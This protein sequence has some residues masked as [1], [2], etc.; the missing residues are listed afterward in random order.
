MAK[1][2]GGMMS[3]PALVGAAAP[4]MTHSDGYIF[5]IIRNG[6]GLMPS[7][8]RIEESERWDVVNYIRTLQGRTGIAIDTTHGLPGETGASL[9]PASSTAPT[10]PVP[11]F[12]VT[13]G[14]LHQVPAAGPGA[15]ADTAH[16]PAAAPAAPP[17]ARPDSARPPATRPPAHPEFPK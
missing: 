14:A 10:R 13:P 12:R 2:T 17:V 3:A 15:P 11:Y 8:N 7:Y 9:P 6:R 16:P 5:G 1:Y 4:S